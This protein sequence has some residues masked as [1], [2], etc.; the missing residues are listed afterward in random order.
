[1]KIKKNK[2]SKTDHHLL[3]N[4]LIDTQILLME[5]GNQY[6]LINHNL[7]VKTLHFKFQ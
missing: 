4:K 1:M 6:N 7:D 3:F 5:Q 2:I